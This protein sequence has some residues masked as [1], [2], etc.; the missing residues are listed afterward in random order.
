MVNCGS[1]CLFAKD[2][3]GVDDDA[4]EHDDAVLAVALITRRV[5]L[6]RNYCCF[7]AVVSFWTMTVLVIS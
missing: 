3:D 5:F 7:S 6:N 2:V 4:D 1:D